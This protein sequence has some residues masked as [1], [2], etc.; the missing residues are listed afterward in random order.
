MSNPN[1]KVY[2]PENIVDDVLGIFLPQ[3]GCAETVLEPFAGKGAFYDKF[4]R[5]RR[6]W[7]EIDEGV[8]FMGYESYHDWIITNPPYSTFSVFLPKMLASARNVVVVI[9][10]NKLLSSMPR[11]MDIR[12]AGANI[13]HIHYLGSGR[14]LNFPFGF[15]V[16][17][18]HIVSGYDGPIEVTYAERCYDARSKIKVLNK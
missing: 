15:P 9:P 7:C 14:Q 4:P 10:T 11:L 2:T 5:G 3:V 13:K 16:S 8:D 12:R 6:F 17:A 18:I 1:D